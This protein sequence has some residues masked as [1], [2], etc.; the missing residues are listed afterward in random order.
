[1]TEDNPSLDRFYD[2]VHDIN[3]AEG[4]GSGAVKENAI[5]DLIG[6]KDWEEMIIF[7]AGQRFDNVGIGKKTAVKAV[8][9]GF[10]LLPEDVEDI[11]AQEGSVTEALIEMNPESG[12]K[13]SARALYEDVVDLDSL[14]GNRAEYHLTEMLRQYKHP[15][16]VSFAV[17]NDWSIGVTE[18]SIANAVAKDAGYSASGRRRARALEPDALNFIKAVRNGDD[19]SSPSP[20]SAFNPML[21]K[22][23]QDIP[24]GENWVAQFKLDGYRLLIH[25]IEDGSVK[26]YSRNRKDVTESLP[27]LQEIDWPEGEHVFDCEVIAEDGTYKS[28]SQ[29]IGRKSSNLMDTQSM[30]FALFDYLYDGGDLTTEPFVVRYGQLS[31]VAPR[32]DERIEVLTPYSDI[33][34]A[35]K[36]AMDEGYEGLIV[37]DNDAE[38]HFGKR[39]KAWRKFK[40]TQ[41]TCDVRIC[42]FERGTGENKDRLGAIVLGTEDGVEIGN[43]GTGFSHQQREEIWDEKENLIGSVV[44]VSHE[45]FTDNGLR[46]PAFEGIR[47]DKVE[48]DTLDRVKNIAE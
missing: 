7:L 42:D 30:N 13:D 14:S 26:A 31:S 21:A 45:G 19:I 32:D 37:K 29:R 39:S 4:K 1:M 6:T 27:E 3:D 23:N 43:C 18:T 20:G 5:L 46:F 10:N 2:V 38:Y 11:V 9:K 47:Y 44:E 40:F 12:N 36:W 34:Q 33:D 48:A 35:R 28:T 16:L 15:H 24:D 41:E 8:T 22:S 17:L 25:V